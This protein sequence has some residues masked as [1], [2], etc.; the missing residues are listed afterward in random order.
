MLKFCFNPVT[1]HPIITL[2]YIKNRLTW[3]LTWCG[4]TSIKYSGLANRVKRTLSIHK[5]VLPRNAQSI[6]MILGVDRLRV[7]SCLVQ[8]ILLV[9]DPFGE[10]MLSCVES[11][12][13]LYQLVWMSACS[14]LS[15][16]F[17]IIFHGH[18]HD[19]NLYLENFYQTR[20]IYAFLQR[21]QFKLV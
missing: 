16:S 4:R 3:R 19:S 21:P 8:P 10:E 14:L 7:Y 17:K 13:V 20:T 11:A 9:H 12:L 6:Q 2:H 18:C 1:S 15:A 5:E